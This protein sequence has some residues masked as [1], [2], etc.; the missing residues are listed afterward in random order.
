[1]SGSVLAAEIVSFVTEFD[2]TSALRDVLEEIYQQ[3]ILLYG[4]TDSYSFFSTVTQYNALREQRLS[5][6]VA[7]VREAY[8][9]FEL[10]DIGFVKTAYN[11]ADPTTKH[12]KNTHIDKLFD[13]GV[14][15]H[16][17]EEYVTHAQMTHDS[18]FDEADMPS[19]DVSIFF[20]SVC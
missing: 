3:S 5:I 2:V 10:S 19:V 6:E 17:V 1:V 15:D 4:L 12:V 18:L 14:V 9:K 11:L 13:T 20:G 8:A 16:P 7:V